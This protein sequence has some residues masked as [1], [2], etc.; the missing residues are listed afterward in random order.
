MTTKLTTSTFLV[1]QSSCKCEY[2]LISLQGHGKKVMQTGS[3]LTKEKGGY[4]I[5]LT[6]VLIVIKNLLK[7]SVDL[8]DVS[9]QILR[10]RF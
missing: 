5:I 10:K 3:S 8:S 7:L 2:I 9:Q 4:F 1:I 6:E